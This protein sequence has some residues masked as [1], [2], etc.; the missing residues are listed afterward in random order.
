[1]IISTIK[2]AAGDKQKN[3]ALLVLRGLITPTRAAVG[4]LDCCLCESV[5]RPERICFST[6]WNDQ[7]SLDQYICSPL[8]G[9]V[10]AVMDMATQSPEVSFNTVCETRGMDYVTAKRCNQTLAVAAAGSGEAS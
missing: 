10:L 9:R 8:Y 2:I 3:R 6:K 7:Q 5:L 1:M 4:C